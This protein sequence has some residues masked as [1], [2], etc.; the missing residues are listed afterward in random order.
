MVAILTLK[1]ELVALG[2]SVMTTEEMMAESR[3]LCVKI[4]KVFMPRGTYPK[5]KK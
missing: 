2:T 3:G 5:I 1:G 4:D